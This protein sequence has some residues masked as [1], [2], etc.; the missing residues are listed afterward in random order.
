[1]ADIATALITLATAAITGGVALAGVHLTNKANTERLRLQLKHESNERH[2]KLMQE[3]AEELYELTEKWL[4]G[5]AV[6]F[7]NLSSVME[8]KFDYSQY[9]DQ[10]IKYGEENK[11]NFSRLEMI[12]KIYFP[13]L[14]PPYKDI[15]KA[16]DAANNIADQH[17]KE[18]EQGNPDG[19]P[20]LEP[21][22]SAHLALNQYGDKFLEG[23]AHCAKNV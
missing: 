20:F 3:K 18:Y 2:R 13:E 6:N 19:R 16:R 9:L 4:Q 8:G 7:L 11:Q 17:K 12:V 21:F 23:I 14:L 5:F 22:R 10:I 15:I 1:L